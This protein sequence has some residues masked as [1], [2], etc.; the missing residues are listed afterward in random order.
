MSPHR[1]KFI[2]N[3]RIQSKWMKLYRN[4]CGLIRTRFIKFFL[5]LN[6]LD[7]ERLGNRFRIYTEWNGFNFSELDGLCRWNH[8]HSEWFRNFHQGTLVTR[9]N[10]LSWLLKIKQ[11]K[12][13]I[14]QPWNECLFFFQ[15]SV[16]LVVRLAL[17]HGALPKFSPQDNP[18]AFHPC[19]H[20]RWV[21]QH[22]S[23]MLRARN[24]DCVSLSR[25]FRYVGTLHPWW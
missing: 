14:Q 24:R 25:N 16:L 13:W 22:S 12:S 9:R 5:D 19:F 8:F 6:G 18:A 17:L 23:F 3:M 10:F 4:S 2:R 21:L 11:V 7:A 1:P 20:V 15:L